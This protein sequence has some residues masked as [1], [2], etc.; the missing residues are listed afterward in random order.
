MVRQNVKVVHISLGYSAYLNLV[1]E[2]IAQVLIVDMS[3]LKKTQDCLDRAYVSWQCD[4]F[5]IDNS[6]VYHI[7]SKIFMDK[8]TEG[9]CRMVQLC[10]SVFK[11]NFSA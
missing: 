1:E 11:S 4:V 5:K 9:V 10:S 7:I 3:N 2:M 8:D 6:L